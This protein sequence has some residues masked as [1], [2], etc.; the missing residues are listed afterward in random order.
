MK[1]KKLFGQWLVIYD[2]DDG[3]RICRLKYD[4]TDILANETTGFQPPK[5]NYG[6]YERRPV[7]GYDDCFPT[8][9]SCTYP[10][11][12]WEIPDH[13]EL[14]WMPWQIRKEKNKLIFSV[15]S[16]NLPVKFTREMHFC[17]NELIWT[18]RVRNYGKE[19]LPFQHVMHPL[20]PLNKITELNFPEFKTIFDDIDQTV[21]NLKTPKS[22]SE[23]LLSRQP[24]SVSMLFLQ[25]IEK[26]YMSWKY[27]SGIKLEVS[28]SDNM[29]Q[30]IGIWWNNQSHPDEDFIR[31]TECAF[32]PV[33]GSTTI[34][35]DANNKNECLM[36]APRKTMSWQIKWL[37]L[38]E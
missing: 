23:F 20:M 16:K 33:S 15:N 31:R 24:G 17:Q 5:N 19:T 1:E 13:G 27:D 32:E 28:F 9:D 18:F 38:Q 3:A 7:Y 22:V 30:T 34:L 36:I 29:F 14:C 35:S 21:L 8:V 25:Q 11:S 10:N 2:S 37:I 12:D 4:D 6:E 26:G